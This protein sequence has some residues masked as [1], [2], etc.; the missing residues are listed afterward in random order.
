[1]KRHGKRGCLR[2]ALRFERLEDRLPLAGDVTASLNASGDIS[3]FGDSAENAIAVFIRQ[4]D[5][6]APD[7]LVVQGQAGTTVGG[8]AEQT[9]DVPAGGFHDL[10]VDLGS[11]QVPSGVERRLRGTA[12]VDVI[13]VGGF[14]LSGAFDISGKNG[15]VASLHDMNAAGQGTITFGAGASKG[16]RFANLRFGSSISLVNCQ[17]G[18]SAEAGPQAA[19]GLSITT[20]PNVDVVTLVDT[21]VG[22]DMNI[23]TNAGVDTITAT[24]V[25][26]GGALDVS[27]AAGADQLILTDFDVA[28]TTDVDM[29]SE[30][31]TVIIVSGSQAS[32]FHD[33]AEFHLGTGA[34]NVF[35]GIG[36][37]TD[38]ADPPNTLGVNFDGSLTID[39]KGLSTVI[40]LG[41]VNVATDLSITTGSG[42]DVVGAVQL[43]VQGD[44]TINTGGGVDAIVL[45]AVYGYTGDNHVGGATNIDTGGSADIVVIMHTT[46]DGPVTINLGAGND[47]LVMRHNTFNPNSTVSANGGSGNNT[48]VF[49]SSFNPAAPNSLVNFRTRTGPNILN[50]VLID[51]LLARAENWLNG[52]LE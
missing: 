49:D 16:P 28:G 47:V 43:D 29:G 50:E 35:G 3:I 44:L 24:N 13:D 41:A 18:V 36:F 11:A 19:G 27:T 42:V 33:D 5:A 10:T 14:D 12:G 45:G 34:T 8:A 38:D 32:A 17:I 20:G 51:F 9:F 37:A 48:A 23:T 31:D 25:S 4:Q 46:F 39:A 30:V 52:V 22:G 40:A 6:P 15:G 1:M 7:L 21:T 2:S 26:V